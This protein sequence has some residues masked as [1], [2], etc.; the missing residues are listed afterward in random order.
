MYSN[1]RLGGSYDVLK[2]GA[3]EVYTEIIKMYSV[4]TCS[5]EDSSADVFQS[6][7]VGGEHK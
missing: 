1:K 6:G 2:T 4:H 7:E 5:Y 3:V